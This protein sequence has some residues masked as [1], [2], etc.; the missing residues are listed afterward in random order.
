MLLMIESGISGGIATITHRHNKANNEYMR[1][2]FDPARESKLISYLSRQV[3]KKALYFI[4]DNRMTYNINNN[5]KLLK[6][7][8][9]Y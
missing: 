8:T 5:N 3:S 2:A 7:Y 4:N 9:H 1:V 6:M